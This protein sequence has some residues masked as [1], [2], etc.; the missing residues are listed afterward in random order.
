MRG[1]TPLGQR[2]DRAAPLEREQVV[3]QLRQV[4][5]LEKHN[6]SLDA[7]ALR[8]DINEAQG[9]IVGLRRRYLSREVAVPQGAQQPRRPMRH[10][11]SARL[12]GAVVLNLG[13]GCVFLDLLNALLGVSF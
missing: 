4:S 11:S 9:H 5:R 6:S 13:A 8:R 2:V 10:P 7:A 3:K 12:G 1:R